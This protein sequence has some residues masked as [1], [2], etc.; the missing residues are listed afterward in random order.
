MTKKRIL[1][2]GGTGAI[3]VYLVP[4]LL[5][6]GYAVDVTSRSGG[7]KG[8][9]IKYIV[10]DAKDNSFLDDVLKNKYHAI[11]DFMGYSTDE[12]EQRVD[13]LLGS[14]DQ[15]IF[16]STYRVFSDKDKIIT[17]KTPRLLDVSE[18]KE[19]LDTDEYALAK[20]RSEDLLRASGKSNWTIVRPSITYSKNRFQLGVL[21]SEVF[22]KRTLEG[23]LVPFPQEMLHRKTTMTW[24]GDVAKMIAS[25]ALNPKAYGEDFN[26]V[27]S[28][29]RT[30]LE[31]AEIYKKAINLKLKEVNLDEFMEIYPQKY[32]VIYDRMFDRVMDNSKILKILNLKQS[33]LMNLDEGLSK[34]LSEFTKKPVFK[35]FNNNLYSRLNALTDSGGI[36]LAK[37]LKPRTRL[38]RLRSKLRPRTRLKSLKH[39]LRPRTRLRAA[40]E[41]IVTGLAVRANAQKD[42]LIVTM[43][44]NFNYGNIIQR[45]ALKTYLKKK[46][47]NFDNVSIRGWS[48]E[49][50]QAPFV[51]TKRFVAQYIGGE[52]FSAE[53]HQGYRNYVVG[54]DQVWRNW[55]GSWEEFSL[56]FLE[57]LGDAET[58]R[59]AYA[60]SFGVDSLEQAKIDSEQVKLI[61][62]LIRKFNAISVREKSGV[63]LVK[64]LAKSQ[65][66]KPVVVLDPVF[67]LRADDYSALIDSSSSRQS[68]I[69]SVFCYILDDS[70]EKTG[71]IKKIAKTK[72]SDPMVI[73]PQNDKKYEPVE[74]WLK[75]FRDS[76]IVVTDSFHGVVLSVVNN[77]EFIVIG[78]EERGMARFI[79]VLEM[80]GIGRDRLVLDTKAFDYDKVEAIDWPLVNKRL[81]KLRKESGDWLLDSLR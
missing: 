24:A 49:I 48:D 54:S 51:E 9:R 29:S 37:K 17:E 59:I 35:D 40:K 71:V 28:E 10:G 53:R 22:V 72:N 76:D 30:W 60:A 25:L 79:S 13:R 11:I 3:G 39:R 75:G 73:N 8:L 18:D 38:K 46:D 34:E 70:K 52:E 7:R 44:S 56:Y 21:E 45:Y 4:E 78:N 68:D 64:Q 27:T 2:L 74:L 31:V 62:P 5:K 20:A 14:T 19:F 77:R 42:G 26:V 36:K 50:D 65:S 16:T 81:E 32:Q 61:R 43:A 12:F 1:L 67:M 69:P 41:R 55:W 58:N 57:F 23:G 66:I 33:D 63:K 47:L 6:K 80:L 15:Y